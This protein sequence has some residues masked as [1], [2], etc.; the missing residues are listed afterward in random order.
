MNGIMKVVVSPMCEELLKL[1]D[2][3][4]YIVTKKPDMVPNVDIAITLSETQTNA[5]SIK[6]K[7]N[8]FPQIME[9]IDLIAKYLDISDIKV[10]SA[11]KI[12]KVSSKWANDE[13]K[14][15]FVEKNGDIKVK[16]Y[17]KFLKDTVIDM[18]YQVVDEN[19]DFIVYPDYIEN[20]INLP[21]DN[22]IN[23]IKI[24]SHTNVPLNPIKRVAKRYELLETKLCMK[25]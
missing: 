22:N 19:Y 4:E 21:I 25:H 24:P 9:S 14:Q 20:S 18:G 10:K 2:V 11:K 16:V 3:N 15:E 23:I 5:P 8:T 13:L 7:L 17:S 6:L 1:L 12:I